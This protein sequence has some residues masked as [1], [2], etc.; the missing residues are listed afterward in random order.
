LDAPH[1]SRKTSRSILWL[2]TAYTIDELMKSLLVSRTFQ[3]ITL[4]VGTFH[5]LDIT[6]IAN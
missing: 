3:R 1:D 4:D 6:P 2:V 5:T